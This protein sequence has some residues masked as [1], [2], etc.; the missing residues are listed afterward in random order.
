MRAC[1]SA[2]RFVVLGVLLLLPL[3]IA[4]PIDAR[5]KPPGFPIP[6]G[7]FTLRNVVTPGEYAQLKVAIASWKREHAQ[8]PQEGEGIGALN[9][10]EAARIN[11]GALGEGMVVSFGNSSP[12]CGGTGNCPMALFVSG[13]K[14]YRLALMAG[15]W[16]YALL[17]SSGRVP[18]IAFYWNMSAGESDA[19][20]YHYAHGQFAATCRAAC[21]GKSSSA[22]CA[23]EDK[24][25]QNAQE[26]RVSP[27][28]YDALRPAVE[29]DLE[30]QAPMLA[31]Q[32]PFKDA[33]ALNLGGSNLALVTA[34]ALGTPGANRN[35]RISI[36]AHH[37]QGGFS[38]YG[39]G[40]YWPIL[41]QVSGWGVARSP[42]SGLAGNQVSYVIARRLSPNQ[43]ELTRYTMT[44]TRY[45]STYE[46]THSSRL[47]PD[48]CE[49]V[50][51]KSGHWPPQWN[52]AAL[53]AHPV[54][55]FKTSSLE[56]PQT[57]AADTT[58]VSAAV[59][60]SDG[61]VWAAGRLWSAGL[62]RWRDGGWNDVASPMP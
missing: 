30:K 55:C 48:A 41:D 12:P 24:A 46:L 56:R 51:P 29:A 22:I 36:Y 23:A 59:Q 40:S 61:T 31:A 18:D 27:A 20:V 37:Y 21:T 33:R 11:L 19:Q 2:R 3:L 42:F 17:P 26:M 5:V 34:L 32:Y 62:Y 60:D 58:N 14:G 53:V 10:I 8:E 39:E 47:L 49:I 57:P 16:G 6:T 52:A 54:P 35:C 9:R 7:M 44:L 25:S 38:L 50:A 13:V 43:D 15:G 4:S 45:D 1:T 28:E